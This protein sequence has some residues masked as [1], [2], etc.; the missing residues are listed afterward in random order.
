[1]LINLISLC[2]MQPEDD[3]M[4]AEGCSCLTGASKPQY[5]FTNQADCGRQLYQLI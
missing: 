1:M 3:C 5:S 4:A 2:N